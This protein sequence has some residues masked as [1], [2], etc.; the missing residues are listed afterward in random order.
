MMT[1]RSS[2][3]M[4]G[5]LGSA[6][7][8]DEDRCT[9]HPDLV[10]P[11]DRFVQGFSVFISRIRHDVSHEPGTFGPIKINQIER[12]LDAS[13]ARLRPFRGGPSRGPRCELQPAA[14]AICLVKQRFRRHQPGSRGNDVLNKPRRGF[15]MLPFRGGFAMLNATGT[16]WKTR[17]QDRFPRPARA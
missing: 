4:P 10:T 12:S 17:R 9:I 6:E 2:L 1:A 8:R 11:S 16:R 14:A 7:F 15:G 13:R 5:G 3:A